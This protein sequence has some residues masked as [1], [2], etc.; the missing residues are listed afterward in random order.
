M[1]IQNMETYCR[2]SSETLVEEL[3]RE[4]AQ[5]IVE[6]GIREVQLIGYCMGGLIALETARELART[7]VEIKDFLIVDSAPV[8]YDIGESIALELMFITNYFITVEDV[9]P[10]I[11]NECPQNMVLHPPEMPESCEYKDE[12][13]QEASLPA[14]LYLLSSLWYLHNHQTVVLL[15]SFLTFPKTDKQPRTC[16]PLQEF[17]NLPR[18]ADSQNWQIHT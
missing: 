12:N 4:Y 6:L 2:Q 15:V 1:T 5:T 11:T 18:A 16:L 8:F 14:L 9:Y 13:L 7:E 17:R 10:E 3:G